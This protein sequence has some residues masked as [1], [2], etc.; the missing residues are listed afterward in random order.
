MKVA[1]FRRSVWLWPSGI[2][3]SEQESEDVV[4]KPFPLSTLNLN[5]QFRMKGKLKQFTE[6]EKTLKE[7]LHKAQQGK[8]DSN[9]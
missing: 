7:D 4:D 3:V 1:L 9:T 8:G 5:Q 2:Q 6:E